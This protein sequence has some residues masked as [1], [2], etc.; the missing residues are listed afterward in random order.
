MVVIPADVWF[1][2]RV[3]DPHFFSGSNQEEQGLK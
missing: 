3:E 1:V 2:G